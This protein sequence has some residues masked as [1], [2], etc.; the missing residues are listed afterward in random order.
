VRRWEWFYPGTE[1]TQVCQVHSPFG[2][3]VTP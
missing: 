1:P 3:G 2:V